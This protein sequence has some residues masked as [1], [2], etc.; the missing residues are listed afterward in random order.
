MRREEEA[1]ST[2]RRLT[3]HTAQDGTAQDGTAPAPAA[4]PHRLTSRVTLRSE[5]DLSDPTSSPAK[6]R[7]RQTRASS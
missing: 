3:R 4:L 2:Q 1:A 5:L 6:T 7:H